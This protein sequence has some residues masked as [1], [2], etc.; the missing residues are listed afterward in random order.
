MGRIFILSPA[1]AGGRR[2]QLLTH[3][4]ANFELA[5]QIQIGDAGLG[6]VFSFCSGLYFRGKLTYA[7][8]FARPPD[9]VPG[10]HIITPSRGLLSAEARIGIA[11]LDEF[12][13]VA[14][15]ADESR[16]TGPLQRSAE[17][18]AARTCEVVL[19]G[20]IATGK[21]ANCLLPILGSRLLFPSEFVGRGHMSRG[22]LLLS[23]A[24]RNEEL[25]YVALA[26]AVRRGRRPLK[27]PALQDMKSLVCEEAA[28]QRSTA[29]SLKRP[30]R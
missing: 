15:D 3:P 13:T 25:N 29:P 30:L 1:R 9:E 22:A 26:G 10:V 6:E 12:V 19:L 8:K 14:I 23:C 20:S 18:L 16:F 24:A 2:A 27:L 5:R 17:A 28:K 21:Y 11:E 4:Q 7:R